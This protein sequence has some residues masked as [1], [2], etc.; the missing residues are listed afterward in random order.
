MLNPYSD[1]A[2]FFPPLERPRADK[3]VIFLQ[4][5]GNYAFQQALKAEEAAKA[6]MLAMEQDED[7]EQFLL[8]PPDDYDDLLAQYIDFDVRADDLAERQAKAY[9]SCDMDDDDGYY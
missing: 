6:Q 1:G 5:L 4:A 2:R 7:N 8:L 3:N 9:S